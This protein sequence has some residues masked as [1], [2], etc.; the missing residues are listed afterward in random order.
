VSA[1]GLTVGS[2]IVGALI[3]AK[4]RGVDVK[5]IADRSTP[6]GRGSGIEPLAAAGV[7]TWIDNQARIAHT[8]AM[9]LDSEATLMGSM[10][11]TGG[12]ARN[13]EDLNLVASRPVAEAYAAHWRERLAVSVPFARREDWCRELTAAA[14]N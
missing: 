10:N 12:A 7:P 11:W 8:K 6:C 9:V 13:S 1:Y 3:R 4:E 5:L 14:S 2:G